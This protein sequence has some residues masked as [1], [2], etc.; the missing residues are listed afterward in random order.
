MKAGGGRYLIEE[1]NVVL[2]CK[3]FVGKNILMVSD[4]LGMT[5]IG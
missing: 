3:D 4:Y 5:F 2:L 1:M